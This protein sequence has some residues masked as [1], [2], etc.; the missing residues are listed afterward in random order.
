ME[1]NRKPVRSIADYQRVVA[2]AKTGDILALYCY[3]PT[4]DQRALVTVTVE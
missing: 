4:L 2:A 3:D 1:I